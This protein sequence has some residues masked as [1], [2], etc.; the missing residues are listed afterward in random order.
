[1]A[2]QG[3]LTPNTVESGQAE[4]VLD[5]EFQRQN[6]HPR[7]ASSYS[8]VKLLARADSVCI[9]APSGGL[10]LAGYGTKANLLAAHCYTHRCAPLTLAQ[11]PLLPGRGQQAVYML[12]P[13]QPFLLEESTPLER[14][15]GAPAP[16][17]GFM[18]QD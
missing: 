12:I 7:P 3:A 4:N 1:M 10:I 11:D 18:A 8:A 16:P 9:E 13:V 15:L 14:F 6:R 17:A 5:K 2:P